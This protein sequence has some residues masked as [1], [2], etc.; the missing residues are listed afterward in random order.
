VE[1]CELDARMRS[2]TVLSRLHAERVAV[3]ARANSGAGLRRGSMGG[4]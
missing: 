1:I 4:E 3:S 2:V